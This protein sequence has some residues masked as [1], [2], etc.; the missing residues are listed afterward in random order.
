MGHFNTFC[1]SKGIQKDHLLKLLQ[2]L[3]MCLKGMKRWLKGGLSYTFCSYQKVIVHAVYILL[4]IACALYFP[5][6]NSCQNLSFL[7]KNQQFLESRDL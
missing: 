6:Q 2:F 1:H 4:V 7:R 3:E 5:R